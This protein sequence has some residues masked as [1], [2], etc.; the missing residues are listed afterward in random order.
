MAKISIIVPVYNVEN[1]LR[2]CL[3]SLVAQTFYDIEIICIND[4]STDNSAKILEEYA[5]RDNRIRII[6]QPNQGPSVARNKGILEAT[7]EYIFFVDSDDRIESNTCELLYN[8][9]T[10]TGADLI[11]FS[12]YLDFDTRLEKNTRL[13]KQIR[14]WNGNITFEECPKILSFIPMGVL[15]KFYKRDFII[16]NKILF[17]ENVK[18]GEDAIFYMDVLLKK[19]KCNY[20]NEYLYF[21]RKNIHSS[22]SADDKIMF[23]PLFE[24]R[25]NVIKKIKSSNLKNKEK[26]LFYF[27]E[28]LTR[29][30]IF[31]W[32][33]EYDF[34]FKKENFYFLELILKQYKNT[35]KNRLKVAKYYPILKRLV[36]E[37]KNIY[38]KKMLEPIIEIEFRKNKFVLYLFERQILN[39]RYRVNK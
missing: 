34:K 25:I 12:Y 27:L 38:F 37:H 23:K 39:I 4:S 20:L 9:T 16:D 30:L 29:S 7:G 17:A 5:S 33:G 26:M 35:S 10:E 32:D 18:Y 28:N 36:F 2:D 6:N 8:R 14:K 1:Y 11:L 22:L 31:M 19:A 21:Y 24:D 13:E 15:G 3:D